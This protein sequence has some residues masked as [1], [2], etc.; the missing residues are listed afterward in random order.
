MV[1][2]GRVRM[3]A[4]ML[5]HFY[6]D[7]EFGFECVCVCV[8]RDYVYALHIYDDVLMLP[9]E[10]RGDRQISLAVFEHERARTWELLVHKRNLAI[11]DARARI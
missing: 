7:I 3:Y 11:S 2:G 4:T 9:A 8:G 10:T 1:H 5:A 6:A